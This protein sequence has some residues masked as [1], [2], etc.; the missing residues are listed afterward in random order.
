ME[1]VQPPCNSAEYGFVHA[2]WG[3]YP[4]SGCREALG[5]RY[6]HFSGRSCHLFSE[7]CLPL[8]ALEGSVVP[9]A[10]STERLLADLQ[11][12][13]EPHVFIVRRGT[14]VAVGAGRDGD[15]VGLQSLEEAT[16][17][18]VIAC[19]SWLCRAENADCA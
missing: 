17:G 15:E 5:I 19:R 9:K 7:T 11:A 2:R 14:V 12:Y 8:D 4:D 13:E 1:E 3:H 16:R 10:R 6:L 18:H